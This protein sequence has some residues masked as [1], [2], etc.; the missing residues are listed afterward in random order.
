MALNEK[1]FL[2]FRVSL[3]NLE[4]PVKLSEELRFSRFRVKV[5]EYRCYDIFL[6]VNRHSEP[7]T[8]KRKRRVNV[9]MKKYNFTF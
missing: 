6:F 9:P 7:E 3:I 5:G 2:L 1:R 4:E 8:E